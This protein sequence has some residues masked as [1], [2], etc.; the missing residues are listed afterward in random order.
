[1]IY[2]EVI[3]ERQTSDEERSNDLV[4]VKRGNLFSKRQNS[5]IWRQKNRN[6]QEKM[7]GDP[8]QVA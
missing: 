5:R 2:E 3:D 8:G 7:S 6:G 1:M 4:L